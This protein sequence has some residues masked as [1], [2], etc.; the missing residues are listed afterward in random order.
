MWAKEQDP[1]CLRRYSSGNS[2]SLART[3]PMLLLF[4]LH[5]LG[6]LVIIVECYGIEGDRN[7]LPRGNCCGE[8]ELLDETELVEVE[9]ARWR[10]HTTVTLLYPPTVPLSPSLSSFAD[11]IHI[12]PATLLS[13]VKTLPAVITLQLAFPFRI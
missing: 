2:V 4:P 3:E 13:V 11:D 7:H 6:T 10:F 9:S 8:I 12:S 5:H 1:L